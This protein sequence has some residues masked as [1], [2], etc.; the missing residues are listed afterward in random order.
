MDTDSSDMYIV[1][2]SYR[3]AENLRVVTD[4]DS[5]SGELHI[6]EGTNKVFTIIPEQEDTSI[7]GYTTIR[8]YIIVIVKRSATVFG[9]SQDEWAIFKYDANN[10]FRK[11]LVAGWF[12]KKIWPDDWDAN[13]CKTK[14]LSLVTRWESKNNVKLYIANEFT[15]ILS[16]NIIDEN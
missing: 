11:T 2:G 13:E 12:T 4:E 15:E 5:N 7:L 1:E 9:Q 3:Y 16:I 8:N 6:I 14:P 10:S